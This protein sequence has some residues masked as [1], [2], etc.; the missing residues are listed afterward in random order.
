MQEN[1][2]EPILIDQTRDKQ[3]LGELLTT[4]GMKL[5]ESEYFMLAGE[6]MIDKIHPDVRVMLAL[7]QDHLTDQDIDPSRRSDQFSYVLC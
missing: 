5:N 3:V 4:A 1:Q 6:M 7:I 2:F